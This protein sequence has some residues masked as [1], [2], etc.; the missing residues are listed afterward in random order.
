VSAHERALAAVSLTT[1]EGTARMLH[2]HRVGG[3]TGPPSQSMRNEEGEVDFRHR[4]AR[5]PHTQVVREKRYPGE[6]MWDGPR[7][8]FRGSAAEECDQVP[9]V[10]KPA[11][12]MPYSSP[13]WLLDA[14]CGARADAQVIAEET[15]RGVPA[16]HIR[17]TVDTAKARDGSPEGLG[18]PR[19]PAEAFPAEVW[20]DE[21]GRICRMSCVWPRKARRWRWKRFGPPH[22]VFTE[23]WDFGIPADIPAPR[24]D[25]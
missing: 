11:G 18:F 3:P 5:Y 7:I 14:L 8:Y 20:L 2:G 12:V 21:R 1:R 19:T 9:L 13:L 10:G 15:V 24:G 25:V 6:T 16:S 23:F 4:R 17:L 22:W